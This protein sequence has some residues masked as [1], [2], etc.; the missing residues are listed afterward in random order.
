ME[1]T[2]E[3]KRNR[4]FDYCAKTGCKG[5]CKLKNWAG[6]SKFLNGENCLIIEK[7]TEEE[8]DKALE[9]I[10]NTKINPL[11]ANKIKKHKLICEK[12]NKLY[13]AKN[14]DYG[15][16]FG[17]SYK[18]YGLTMSCI[19]LEDKLNRL[20]SLNFSRTI[21]VKNE[22]IEDTLM[23]L[24]NYAIMTLIELEGEE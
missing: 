15:D 13:E 12:L 21:K 20:K 7:A 2:I 19:R 24:A 23:D 16:S 11:E 5:D 9:L 14:A 6:K 22:S 1:L 10:N 17:K 18:E 8:L 3:K 4:V